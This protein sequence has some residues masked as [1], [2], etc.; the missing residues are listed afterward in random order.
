MATQP[1]VKVWFLFSVIIGV[2][3]S[4]TVLASNI[5][6]KETPWLGLVWVPFITWALYFI[7]GSRLSRLHKEVIG[8]VGGVVFGLLTII[9]GNWLN[10]IVG[11]LYGYPLTVFFVAIIIVMLELTDWFELAPAYFFAYA[12]YFAATFGFAEE[13]GYSHSQMAWYYVI[14]SLIGFALAIISSK[15][16]MALMEGMHVPADSRATMFDKENK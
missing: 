8:V 15:I 12:G 9:I 7:A 2:L 13:M 16:R 5:L 3:A 4:L 6:S 10:G 14:L 11:D 1:P